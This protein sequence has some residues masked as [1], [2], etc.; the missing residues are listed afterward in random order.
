VLNLD[1]NTIGPNGA[2]L[3][4]EQLKNNFGLSKL[5]CDNNEIGEDGCEAMA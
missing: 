5:Y 3:I 4:A 2:K 1:N